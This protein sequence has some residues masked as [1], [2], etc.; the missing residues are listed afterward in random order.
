MAAIKGSPKTGGRKAG[1]P[2]LTT[3]EIRGLLREALEPEIQRIPEMLAELEPEQRLQMIV[4]LLPFLVPKVAAA[5][6]MAVDNDCSQGGVL[7]V[8]ESL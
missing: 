2:N 7:S 6:P 1:T 5:Q 4:K 3:K 8:L